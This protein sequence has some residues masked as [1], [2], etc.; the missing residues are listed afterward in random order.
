MH[1]YARDVVAAEQGSEPPSPKR[2]HFTSLHFTFLN[3]QAT[4]S[5]ARCCHDSAIAHSHR[6]VFLLYQRL[7]DWLILD[8]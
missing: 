5:Q 7:A 1:S 8:Y 2:R 4:T 3:A 6:T